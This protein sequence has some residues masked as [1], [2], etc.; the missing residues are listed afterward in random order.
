MNISIIGAG[1]FGTSMAIHLANN[2]TNIKIW[3]NDID[4][5]NEINEHRSNLRYVKNIYN[6]PQNIQASLD[7]EEVLEGTKYIILAVPS[8][9]IKSVSKKIN[10]YLSQ[11]HTI[12]NLAKGLD[13]TSFKRLSEVI[14]EETHSKKV[15]VLSGP[16][17]AEEIVNNIPTTIVAS[18]TDMTLAEEVQKDLSTKTLRIYTNPDIIGVEIGGA[19][20]NI[21]A[22]A[23]GILDGL[24]YGDNA[25][26]A[27][28]VRGLHEISKIGLALGAESLTLGGL[29]GVG[30]LIVT[31][32]SVHSRNRQAGI[33][34]AK[35]NS[36]DNVLESVGMVVEGIKSCECFYKLSKELNIELPITNSLYDIL[37][38][39]SV[40]KEEISN[41]LQRDKKSEF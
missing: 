41:L 10:P 22:L 40:P 2:A 14:K 3:G 39:N 12:I 24:G 37:F 33:L 6:I 1:S 25:K 35:G 28:M 30:D 20:K 23:A 15:V 36:M 26:A 5:V 34:L 11:N 17:H 18:S 21:I 16:S 19:S 32:T 29:S 27:L 8:N 31:C 4:V 38:N 9:A 13:E 7:I